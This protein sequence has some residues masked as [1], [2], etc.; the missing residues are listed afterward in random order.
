MRLAAVALATGCVA[1]LPA[2]LTAPALAAPARHATTSWG[3]VTEPA[4]NKP[5]TN[6][7]VVLPGNGRSWAQRAR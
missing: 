7:P 5:A 3:H 1:A 4:T 6:K 2:G